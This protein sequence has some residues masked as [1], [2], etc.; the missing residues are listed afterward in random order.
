MVIES[1]RK[2]K[3]TVLTLSEPADEIDWKDTEN[4]VCLFYALQGRRPVGMFS[5]IMPRI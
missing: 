3:S 4:E 1:P 2:L 5:F